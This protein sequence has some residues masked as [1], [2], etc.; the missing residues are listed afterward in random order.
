MAESPLQILHKDSTYDSD[1]KT[2]QLDYS[3]NGAL[4]IQTGTHWLNKAG[5]LAATLAAPS[6][7]QNGT[8]MRIISSTA[9]AHTITQTTPGFNNASTSQDVATFG[10][11]I[12]D[13]ISIEAKGGIW[14]VM[15]TR[16]VTLA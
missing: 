4:T 14:Y 16:N 8:R 9:Q 12:G 3:A 5:V 11:A 13:N 1:I 15:G 7:A 6:T 10:G 2:N